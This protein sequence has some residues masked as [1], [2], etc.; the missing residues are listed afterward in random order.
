MIKMIHMNVERKGLAVIVGKN[1][2]V[3]M[4][5]SLCLC[6]TPREGSSFTDKDFEKCSFFKVF[7]EL[8]KTENALVPNCIK[9]FAGTFGSPAI[10]WPLEL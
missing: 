10:E 5:T 1:P 8:L 2:A 6:N 4:G 3:V 9:T 7:T